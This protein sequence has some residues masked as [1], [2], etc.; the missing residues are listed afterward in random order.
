MQSLYILKS[1]DFQL[2]VEIIFYPIYQM[3]VTEEITVHEKFYFSL[4]KKCPT[5]ISHT[6]LNEFK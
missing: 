1:M 6:Q 5:T 4:T 3:N 2:Q